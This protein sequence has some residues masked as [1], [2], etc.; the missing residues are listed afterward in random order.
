MKIIINILI[1]TLCVSLNSYTQTLND[2]LKIAAENNPGLQAKYKDFEAAM[3]KIP[4]ANSLPDPTLSFG[5]FISPVETRVG[6]QKARFSLTQQFPWFGTLKA[7][8][9]AATLMAEAKYQAFIDARNKLYF[10]VSS[11]YFPLFELDNWKKIEEENITILQSYK[12]IVSRRFENG[13]GSLANILRVDM[14]LNDA[15]TNLNILVNKE[16]PLTTAFN[17]LLNR[18]ANETIV[19]SD[20]LSANILTEE[21]RK[22][23][24][25][26]S[27]PII[28]EL[29]LLEQASKATENAAIKQGLPKFGV[30]VDYVIVGERTDIVM[31]EN[32]KDVLMPMVTLSI[33]IFRGK[34]KA[35][36]KEAVLT[37]EKY[38]LQKKD[39][40]NIL[41]AE[42][43]MVLFEINQQLQLI[44]LYENQLQTTNQTL[45]LLFKDYSNSGKDFEEVLQMQQQL[46][47]YRKLKTTAL[48]QYHISVAKF[49]YLTAKTYYNESK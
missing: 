42:Y 29:N 27:N 4:Q 5:Y 43:D 41:T 40:I 36:V 35:A 14:M 2:Y 30:G 23:S 9:D 24:L 17:Q 22:D 46:L 7:Q 25:L 18:D 48:K 32:G 1:I 33:P 20:T 11:A 37:Q 6:P 13:N 45:N 44:S 28:N 26:R 47:K 16:K 3:Q 38:S 8:E 21:Y 10:Q 15:T 12:K 31:P 19:V 34:Y 39:R 49:N